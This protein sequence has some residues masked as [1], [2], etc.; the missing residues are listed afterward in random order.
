MAN[1]DAPT[2][3]K[4]RASIFRDKAGGSRVAGIIT[5]HAATLFEVH[6]RALARL[7]KRPVEKVSDADVIESLC[8]GPEETRRALGLT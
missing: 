8:V 7:A 3:K 2:L 4:G 6:R 1:K 5:K